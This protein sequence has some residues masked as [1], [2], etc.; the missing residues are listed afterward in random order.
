MRHNSAVNQ[1]KMEL[2][3]SIITLSGNGWSQR[4]IARE[5]GINRETVARYRREERQEAQAKP[6]SVPAGSPAPEPG[7]ADGQ[8][9]PKPANLP[10]GSEP[11]R[12]SQ[13]E[14]FRAQITLVWEA[15]LSAQRIYQDLVSDHQFA[16]SYDAVKR[17][18]R[19]LG[20]TEPLPFR[21]METEPGQEAQVDFGQG[22]WVV[23]EGHRRRPH[24]LRVVLSCTRKGY[25]EAFY[26]QTTGELYSRAGK[27]LSALWWCRGYPGHRQ[28][29][30]CGQQS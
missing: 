14:P 19:Q 8:S 7:Q 2:R 12:K 3:Q 1:L 23:E 28:S 4:R 25:T 5:L 27:F 11:V 15:G 24:V 22:A 13:C 9:E 29:A 20:A 21:R 6:A 10:A 18:V 16:G 17:F 30:R 26:R